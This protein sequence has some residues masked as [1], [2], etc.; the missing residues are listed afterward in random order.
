MGLASA[1]AILGGHAPDEMHRLPA[2]DA[3]GGDDSGDELADGEN[4]A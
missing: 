2:A 4:D 1:L 3:V